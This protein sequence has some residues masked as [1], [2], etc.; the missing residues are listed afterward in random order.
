MPTKAE[1]KGVPKKSAA[2]SWGSTPAISLSGSPPATETVNKRK[3]GEETPEGG[4]RMRLRLE[5]VDPALAT[6]PASSA[7]R[8][9][10]MPD[11]QVVLQSPAPHCDGEEQFRRMLRQYVEQGR[12]EELL[13]LMRGGRGVAQEVP[14][15]G[16]AA[17]ES[18]QPEVPLT[19]EK[20]RKEP[21]PASGSGEG[22]VQ[23]LHDAEQGKDDE[24]TVCYA[25]IDFMSDGSMEAQVVMVEDSSETEKSG[26]CE[27]LDQ[28]A[29]DLPVD[30][31]LLAPD[32]GALPVACPHD[33][34]ALDSMGA[35]ATDFPGDK[36]LSAPDAGALPVTGDEDSQWK[37][38]EE[39]AHSLEQQ[40]TLEC[41]P[42][43]EEL[44]VMV[45]PINIPAEALQ[46]IYRMWDG[47][48]PI[49]FQPGT[50]LPSGEWGG[51]INIELPPR[52]LTAEEL[53]LEGRR[54]PRRGMAYRTCR[55]TTNSAVPQIKGGTPRLTH[56]G[57]RQRRNRRGSDRGSE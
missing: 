23:P 27:T 32:T 14:S 28:K 20:G 46:Q 50:L 49:A 44:G 41:Y 37:E 8:A 35:R 30:K 19:T 56:Q 52:V 7:N 26:P 17:V 34:K 24:G 5:R 2:T 13:G 22:T 48:S 31:G 40:E 36:G 53:G 25:Q 43:G 15:P 3:R 33:Q 6:P 55:S 21:P 39:A 9:E 29:T 18:A 1:L 42:E 11:R 16:A 12:G 10:G 38:D 4:R 54:Q 57:A 51:T 47:A 45:P